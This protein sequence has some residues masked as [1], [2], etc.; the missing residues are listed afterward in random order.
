MKGRTAEGIEQLGGTEVPC[1]G[2]IG[3][4]AQA[5]LQLFDAFGGA[6]FHQ[7][8]VGEISAAFGAIGNQLQLLAVVGLGFVEVAL[9]H[10]DIAKIEMG[11]PGGWVVGEGP[12]QRVSMWSR[13]RIAA[14]SGRPGRGSARRIPPGKRGFFAAGEF[15]SPCD[16]RPGEGQRTDTGQVLE[17]IADKG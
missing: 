16:G 3:I 1:I 15:A 13:F 11:D 14:K 7:E 10:E 17:M 12:A 5:L 6:A 4:D 8:Y 2:A 9:P